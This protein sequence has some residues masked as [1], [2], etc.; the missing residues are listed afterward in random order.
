V[1]L[2]GVAGVTDLPGSVLGVGQQ[3]VVERF[4]FGI[5]LGVKVVGGLADRARQAGGIWADLP[6]WRA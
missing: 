6:A 3:A 5:W 4:Y 2:E 1:F